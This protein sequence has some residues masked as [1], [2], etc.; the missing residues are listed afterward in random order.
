MRTQLATDDNVEH[1]RRTSEL[2]NTDDSLTIVDCYANA[3]DT[4]QHT[5]TNA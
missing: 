1:C 2:N 3:D 5:P 4:R